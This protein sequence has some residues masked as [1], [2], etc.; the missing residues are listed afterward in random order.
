MIGFVTKSCL[1][2]L[3]ES[4]IYQDLQFCVV[5]RD[6]FIGVQ[7]T[8]EIEEGRDVRVKQYSSRLIRDKIWWEF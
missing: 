6:A 7:Q 8:S 5:T 4:K 1:M 2:S 3:L